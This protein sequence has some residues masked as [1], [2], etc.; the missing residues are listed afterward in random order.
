MWA[1]VEVSRS[2][3]FGLCSVYEN[4]YIINMEQSKSM[5]AFVISPC[6]PLIHVDDKDRLKSQIS[7]FL[8]MWFICGDPH[9]PRR[10]TWFGTRASIWLESFLVGWC[11]KGF[12]VLED[13]I[14]ILKKLSRLYVV[15]YTLNC[16]KVSKKSTPIIHSKEI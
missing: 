14:D 8:K 2:D 4:C 6:H 3:G 13:I 12:C 1:G 10:P 15:N 7:K 9:A 11:Q 16:H 5:H